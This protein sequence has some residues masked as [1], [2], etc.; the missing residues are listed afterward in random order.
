MEM[1]TKEVV[2]A[3]RAEGGVT[4]TALTLAVAIVMERIKSLPQEDRDDLFELAM[5]IPK[6]ETDEE[7]ESLLTAMLEILEQEPLR[8]IE[9][10]P[11][12]TFRPGKGLQKWID[13]VSK[14]IRALREQAG[15][16]QAELAERTGLPQSHISRLEN[17]Q[18]SPSRKTLEKIAAGLRVEL[19]EIDPSA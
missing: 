2:R 10:D 7:C 18:H 8:L 4:N 9:V 6:A 1:A 5:E 12:E 14:R 11:A 16:T 17:A 15:L 19:K 3:L 13:W